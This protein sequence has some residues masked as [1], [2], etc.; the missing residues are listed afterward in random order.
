MKKMKLKEFIEKYIS[1]NSLI[2]LWR[3]NDEDKCREMVTPDAVMEWEIL[4]LTDK[5]TS[6][7]VLYVTDIWCEKCPEAIN[8][9]LKTDLTRDDVVCE[10]QKLR[11][12][13]DEE[14]Y[15]SSDDWARIRIRNI[16]LLIDEYYG[17]ENT[18]SSL[19]YSQ[20]LYL[21]NAFIIANDPFYKSGDEDNSMIDKITTELKWLDDYMKEHGIT[22][23][24]F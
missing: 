21:K 22:S 20:V 10:F 1:R 8:I 11:K 2:R 6:C 18:F 14:R 19:S 13:L 7:E 17:Y 23:I 4:K 15:R 16:S 5:I 9:V 24:S 12:L 3:N